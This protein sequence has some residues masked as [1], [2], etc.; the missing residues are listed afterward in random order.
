MTSS[1]YPETI[2]EHDMGDDEAIVMNGRTL[3]DLNMRRGADNGIKYFLKDIVR[4]QMKQG[5][6]QSMYDLVSP[7]KKQL[8]SGIVEDEDA[9]PGGMDMTMVV[10]TEKVSGS[11]CS[12]LAAV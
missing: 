10:E 7:L 8:S 4:N 5:A 2:Q 6:A 9:V 1:E 11:I 12:T 3:M